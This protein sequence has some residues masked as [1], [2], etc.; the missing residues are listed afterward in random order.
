LVVTDSGGLQKE[1]GLNLTR[2]YDADVYGGGGERI[3]ASLARFGA[4]S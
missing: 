2:D 1:A 4:G 3:V